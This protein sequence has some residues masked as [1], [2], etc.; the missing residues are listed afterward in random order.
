M[1]TKNSKQGEF[2][3]ST[4]IDIPS[5]AGDLKA[6]IKQLSGMILEE[7][8]EIFDKDA[9]LLAEQYAN[10]LKLQQGD[11]AELFSL[12]NATGD[13]ISLDSVLK[14]G[15]VVLSFYRGT[16]CP[17]CNLQL[18][19]YQQ[20][21]PQIKEAGANL[22]AVSPMNPDNSLG[23]KQTNELEFEVLSDVGNSVARLFTTVFK[24]SDAPIKA[25]TEMGYDFFSFY[26]E[27]S[28]EL[29]VPATFVIAPDRT[30]RF[31]QSE[32]GD[33]RK[34]VEASDILNALEL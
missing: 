27:K 1:T 24:N 4:T 11:K 12:P 26:N 15:T 8:L 10:P 7:K 19:N 13:K 34:R 29:P 25:M 20:I 5:Y 21:L 32:G 18:K 2:K 23:M 9:K 30:I 6:L 16:W 14:Q 22:I 28:G 33:Y 3:M 17:Y 31:A